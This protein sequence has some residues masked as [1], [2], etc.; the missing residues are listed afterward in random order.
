MQIIIDTREFDCDED[1]EA[2]P[3]QVENQGSRTDDPLL[4][5]M[6][7][8]A[9]VAQCEHYSVKPLGQEFEKIDDID[10][11]LENFKYCLLFTVAG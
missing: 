3:V 11:F 5:H 10:Q 7:K 9:A 2:Q 6:D 8:E 4:E 1:G